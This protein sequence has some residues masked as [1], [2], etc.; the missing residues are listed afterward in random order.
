MNSYYRFYVKD[1]TPPE[2][3]KF[4]MH[5]ASSELKIALLS[6]D[7]IK[8]KSLRTTL[9]YRTLYRNLGLNIEY[10]ISLQDGIER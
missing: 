7:Y 8:Y 3:D 9:F 5:N 2:P 1:Y 10:Y 4:I 6:A